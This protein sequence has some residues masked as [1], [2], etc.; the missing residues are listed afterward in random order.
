[1]ERIER[2]MNKFIIGCLAL[3]ICLLLIP[4]ISVNAQL[5]SVSN[6]A[7]LQAAINSAIDEELTEIQIESDFTITSKINIP[8]KKNILLTSS[9]EII[10][11]TAEGT[12]SLFNLEIGSTLTLGGSSSRVIL[13]GN[14]KTTTYI[15]NCDGGSILTLNNTTIKNS[16]GGAIGMDNTD[17]NVSALITVNSGAILEDNLNNKSGGGAIYAKNARVVV[18]GGI[19]RNNSSSYSFGGAIYVLGSVRGSITVNTGLFTG[20]STTGE[21]YA[22]GGG[23]IAI[24]TEAEE[25]YIRGGVFENNRADGGTGIGGAIYIDNG[26]LFTMTNA[27]IT[28]N[29]TTGNGGGIWYCDVGG[30]LYFDEYSVLID[31]NTADK[32]NDF[33]IQ[34]SSSSNRSVKLSNTVLGGGTVEWYNENTGSNQTNL[35]LD[36]KSSMAFT[37]NAVESGTP[38]VMDMA[39]NNAKV[40]IRNNSSTLEGGGIACNGICTFG[41]E[42]P[43]SK[44]VTKTWTGTNN[45]GYK[46]GVQLYKNG[47]PFDV[48]AELN[49]TNNWSYTW[50]DLIDDNSE[51]TVKEVSIND[52]LISG[53]S[54]VLDD[55]DYLGTIDITVMDDGVGNDFSIT[56][57]FVE[58]V[59]LKGDVTLTANKV[60]NG[61]TLKDKEFSFALY[62]SN[63]EYSYSDTTLLETVMNTTEGNIS[64]SKINYGE[65]DIGNHYYVI[66]EVSGSE[67][68]ISYS[69]KVVKVLVNVEK[70]SE[71]SLKVTT[72]YDGVSTIPLFTNTYT[73][74]PTNAIIEALKTLT[75]KML[76]DNAFTFELYSA[77][78][79]YEVINTMPIKT[80]QNLADGSITFSSITYT[81]ANTYF[82]VIKER[83]GNVA[84]FT[85]DTS[86]MH[87]K[88]IVTDVDG[89]LEAAITYVNST[90]ALPTF[91]NSYT[92]LPTEVTLR[93]NKILMGRALQNQE[94]EFG[95]YS[96][97]NN[98]V[99]ND[100]NLI[101]KV[102]NNLDGSIV[103][104]DIEYTVNDI[105][106]HYY[107]IKELPT[108]NGTITFSD[109]EVKVKVEVTKD[110]TDN[111]NTTVSYDSSATIPTFTN[112]YSAPQIATSAIDKE[113]GSKIVKAD[114][115]IT[116]V[117]TITYENLTIGTTY[118]VR[119]ILMDKSKN[120]PLLVNGKTVEQVKTFVPAYSNG[121]VDVE[122]TF[123]GSKLPRMDIVV[124]EEV[125]DNNVLIVSHKDINDLAQTVSLDVIT[126]PDTG[127][128]DKLGVFGMLLI[129][130]A[131]SIVVIGKRRKI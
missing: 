123:D 55:G 126:T 109:M 101:E 65:S 128:N 41:I 105:G 103:F 48:P 73:P 114:N 81:E 15:I 74:K 95:L 111:L 94:F 72:T 58:T 16:I 17:G 2:Y 12:D 13:D 23:A 66:K 29:S 69:E 98:Y 87:V 3:V 25:S 116:I 86:S 6:E 52:V 56:N 19:F 39:L 67:D 8:N 37:A 90:N 79:N 35:N 24:A 31:G 96:T 121:T 59:I 71:T 28:N 129:L 47:V 5:N 112:V 125:Y 53:N 1:M 117:D 49:S 26:A 57:N 42:N 45:P 60:L 70:E 68:T 80:T 33:S 46:V 61:R 119:G 130:G 76:L 120:A 124:F 102:K 108:N 110:A 11:L 131:M 83:N 18:N 51:Y 27:V 107:V 97:N 115:S 93:A 88:V 20:N 100:A 9:K 14:Q 34:G 44:T 89:E 40:I 36:G 63:S 127:V 38:S 62:G 92:P 7:E 91:V 54:Y 99:Y 10:T 21:N 82:Y 75:G 122:F 106:T 85:Y 64:F 32:G 84:G 43:I 22:W 30:G 4:P 78:S 50:S 118:E 77:N 113:T 104:D